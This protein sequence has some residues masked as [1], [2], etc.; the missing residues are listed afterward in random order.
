VT[1]TVA[2]ACPARV[3]PE[4]GETESQAPP[5]VVVAAAAQ[6]R[7]PWPLLEITK[8]WVVGVEPVLPA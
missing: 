2:P 5:E 1:V 3:F 4:A 6:L 7:V 8:V